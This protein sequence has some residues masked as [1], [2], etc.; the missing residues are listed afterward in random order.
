MK[1]IYSKNDVEL[2]PT[3]LRQT[4]GRNLRELAKSYPSISG[5]CREIGINRTQFNRY[6]AGESFPRPEILT[7]ICSFFEV[8]AQ[9]LLVPLSQVPV[10][11]LGTDHPFLSDFVGPKADSIS[12]ERFPSGFYRFTRQSF[13]DT[14]L[15]MLGLAYVFRRDGFTF[16]RGYA[17]RSMMRDLALPTNSPLRE[18]RA[19]VTPQEEGVYFTLSHRHNIASV[20]NYVSRASALHRDV[21]VG[22]AARPERDTVTKRRISRLVYERIGNSFSEVRA[23][24]ASTGYVPLSEIPKLHQKYLRVGTPFN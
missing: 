9:S 23:A 17:S 12:E 19:V 18:F 7:Q 24:A 3:E 2:S 22:F 1:K 20:F 13:L 8:D 15:I 4:F 6:L 11:G 16:L 5:L 10:P 14:D 21:W